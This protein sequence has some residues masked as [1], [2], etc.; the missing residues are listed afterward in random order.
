MAVLLNP[1]ELNRMPVL[2]R[3]MGAIGASSRQDV[4]FWLGVG[5]CVLIFLNSAVTAASIAYQAWFANRQ[6][7]VV[8]SDLFA[9]FLHQ[10]YA[11]HAQTDSGTL[12]KVLNSNVDALSRTTSSLLTIGS[13]ALVMCAMV[14]L[15]VVQASSVALLAVIAFGG[16]Y[17]LFFAAL[18][19]WQVRLGYESSAN[20]TLSN[21][22]ALEA[23]GAIK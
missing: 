19:R 20:P 3:L 21:R 23:F 8:S 15:L 17:A 10:P 16:T 1:A 9:R 6:R 11:F 2:V 14:G 13:R 4:M 12:F 18:R 22:T 7:A 5:V